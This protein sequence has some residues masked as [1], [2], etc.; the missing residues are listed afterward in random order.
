MLRI[1]SQLLLLCSL[2]LMLN[3]QVTVST[4]TGSFN[5]SGGVSIGSD[6][7]IYVADFGIQL[8]NANGTTVSRVS[9]VDGSVTTFANG[10][11]GASGNAF[12]SQGNLF[13]SNISG[14]F[15]SKIDPSGNAAFFTS[16]NISGP[17]GIAIDAS[18]NVYVA[19]CGNNTIA[20][21]TPD[22]ATSTVFAASALLSCPNGLTIDE[23]GNLYTCNFGNGN[24]IKITASG[25]AS[26]LAT[27]P[28]SNNGHLTY[29]NG[30]LF[31][32]DRGGNRIFRV[33]AQTG[34]MAHIAG[35][36]ACGK[37]DG[38]ALEASFSFP[39]GIEATPS[40]DTLYVND[41]VPLCNANLNPIVVRMITGVNSIA[42][43]GQSSL[44]HTPGDLQVGIFNDGSIG[45]MNSLPFSGPGISWKGVNGL[46]TGGLLFGDAASFSLNGMMGS[47]GIFSD[48]LNVSS[49]Y[50]VGFGSNA[51]FDQIS[52]AK[53]VDAGAPSPYLVH[54][55]QESYSNTGDDFVF[56]RYG[57]INGSNT[58]Y[59]GFYSGILIDWDLT[60]AA[61]T[62]SG[63]YALDRHLVY[64]RETTGANPYYYGIAALDGASGMKTVS[65][66]VGINPRFLG[67]QRL[68]N[69]DAN[70]I[71]PAGDYRSWI[72]AGPL[73]LAPG[74]T[75]WTT[76]AIVAGDDLADIRDHADMASQ[77]AYNLGWTNQVTG[78]ED[79][80]ILNEIPDAFSLH[81]NYPNPFNP[82][83]QIRYSLAENAD[84][85]LKIYN[86]L[87]QEIKTLAAEPQSAGTK[88]VYWDG[89]DELGR[90]AASGVYIYRL[91][92][93]SS[94]KS[95][96]F[97]Q[98]RKMI[99]LK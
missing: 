41:A 20:K 61:V 83:T 23:N 16:T 39:N 74:D 38:P 75:A 78:I 40:G 59:N 63:G 1:V 36:G 72:G 51:E 19:N 45:A 80:P 43:E 9:P 25:I 60:P 28:G 91:T 69:L 65:D 90:P 50:A 71:G 14:G 49:D 24:V 27:M 89:R 29:S 76:F 22:G 17:V 42:A 93:R 7:Y 57:F 52:S 55:L 73:V 44:S 4:L 3:A 84:V 5:A 64:N 21:I 82:S 47:F 56:I 68:S 6:G 34:Q 97:T 85:S 13:Q 12:D 92:A 70:P 46:F 88:E 8:N 2:S 54:V 35:S 37:A 77:R 81:G 62:D 32:V 30:Y 31:V 67:F 94:G 96:L 58:T 26:V 87:G 10:L 11:V 95:G 99:L 33:D 18:D 98:T 79:N 48:V 53:L 66:P 15:I 86:L